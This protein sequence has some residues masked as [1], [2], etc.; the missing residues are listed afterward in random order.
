MLAVM[1]KMTEKGGKVVV[2]EMELRM[3]PDLGEW[4]EIT[5]VGNPG[6]EGTGLWEQTILS[7]LSLVSLK[8]P[9]S[10]LLILTE[11]QPLC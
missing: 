1:M 8:C 4:V 5:Q 2:W 11:R 6:A 3:A 9:N 10:L 7:F